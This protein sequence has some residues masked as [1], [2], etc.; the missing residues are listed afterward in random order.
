MKNS[1]IM[2]TTALFIAGCASGSIAHKA[3]PDANFLK[4]SESP[5]SYDG[6]AVT[7]EAWITLRHEDKNLWATWQDHENW[8][9]TRCISLSN[10]DSLSEK[11]DGKRVK[12]TGVLHAD[13]SNGGKLLRLASCR[14]VA[15]EVS[16]PNAIELTP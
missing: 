7:V 10:Y 3:E 9:T 6:K 4:I 13:A 15:I 16:G 8:E 11:L 2:L 1:W 5:S 12:V 14:S